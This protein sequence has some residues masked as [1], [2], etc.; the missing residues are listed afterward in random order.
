MKPGV[1]RAREFMPACNQMNAICL[2]TARHAAPLWFKLIFK[3]S[4]FVAAVNC[5]IHVGCRAIASSKIVPLVNLKFPLSKTAV[6]SS[7]VVCVGV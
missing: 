4:L 2:R 7:L 6:P 1:V 5:V 3:S